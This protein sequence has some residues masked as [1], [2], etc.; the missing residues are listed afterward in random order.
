MAMFIPDA[1]RDYL[2]CIIA[3]DIDRNA[4]HLDW[5]EQHPD[6]P[7]R[8]QQVAEALQAIELARKAQDVFPPPPAPEGSG[9]D[10]AA[11]Q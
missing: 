11:T 5:L 3:E 4:E 10:A 9:E 7:D 6:E 8:E 2:A 1:V